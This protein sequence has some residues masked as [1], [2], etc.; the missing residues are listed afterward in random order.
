MK[1]LAA[2]ALMLALAGAGEAA[3]SGIVVAGE[4]EA[5]LLPPAGVVVEAY[6][7]FG[8][9]LRFVDGGIEVVVDN[10]PI[11]SSAL[12]TLPAAPATD[13]VGR[14]A[15]EVVAGSRT[16]FDAASRLLAWV[17]GNIRYELNRGQSQVPEVVLLR[18]SAFCTGTARLTVALL[19][20]AGIEAREVPGYVLEDQPSGPRAGFHRWVEIRF[21]DRGWVFTDPLASHFFV[22]STY[23]RL[24][25]ERL[26]DAPGHGVL[27][28]RTDRL[29]PVDLAPDA[30]DG[31]RVRANDDR[32]ASATLVVHYGGE[33]QG[34]E[35]ILEGQGVRRIV[36]LER[37]SARFLGL[38]TGRYELKVSTAGR[39]AA[40][41]AVVFRAPV[42]AELVIPAG[43]V[44]ARSGSS[45]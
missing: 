31:V 40:W 44:A 28:S 22:P 39:L 13:A 15:R 30:P 38:E 2:T 23:L 17:A 41:K 8:Y 1:R 11:G 4:D 18:R 24:G 36:A 37:G 33:S 43:L 3:A 26:E 5:R 45:R 25:A 34:G 21:P 7:N 32:R 10:A 12:L 9:E 19:A 6:R 14:L 42:L 20:A 35:A 27:L 16:R 29:E